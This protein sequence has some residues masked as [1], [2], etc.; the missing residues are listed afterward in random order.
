[1]LETKKFGKDR[2]WL[3]I[4]QSLPSWL[5]RKKIIRVFVLLV[6]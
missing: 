3:I 2:L 4:N 5:A 1:M 6:L